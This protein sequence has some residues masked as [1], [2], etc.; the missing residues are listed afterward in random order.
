MSWR[1]CPLLAIVTLGLTAAACTPAREPSPD[2][3]APAA[4]GPGTLAPVTLPDLSALAE[5][6]RGQL[7]ERHE[8]L[9]SVLATESAA[10]TEQASAYG[11]LGRLLLASRFNDEAALCYEHAEALAPDD[12]RWPYFLGHVYLRK[13]ERPRAAAAFERVLKL[14]P[15]DL[16][17]LVWLGEAYLDDSRPDAAQRAFQRALSIEPQS[18]PAL[19]GTGRAALAQQNYRDAAQYLE[20]ALAADSRAS[21]VHYPLAMAYRALEDRERAEAHLRQRGGNFPELS[22]PLLQP[23]GEV[24]HSAIAYENRGVDALKRADFATAAALF[25]RGLELEPNDP[26]LR[27]W[28]GATLYASGD[29]SGAQREFEAV[30]QQS[31]GFAKAHFSLGAVLEAGGRHAA[32]LEQYQEAVKSDPNMPDA[33][34]RLAD[35]LRASGQLQ[36]SMVHYEAAVA[37]D[38]GT[39]EA[40]IG[41]GHALIGLRRNE[42]AAE[43]LARARRIHPNRPEIAEL[44]ARVAI[45]AGSRSGRPAARD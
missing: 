16:T 6:V 10:R 5:S 44:Q 7:R 33:R 32:A 4:S 24:L 9:T 45:A 12:M 41:G 27:Y 37:L 23:D 38:P 36:A 43:W 28:L 29:A 1:V 35:A 20:R 13:G 25:R 26:S 18:A 14:K 40:W 21:A 19:F 34:L 11:D 2:T 42:Q 31:P 30:L 3:S 8:R 22:D 39:A 17:T 15:G